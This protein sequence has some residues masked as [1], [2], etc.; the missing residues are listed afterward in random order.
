MTRA[1]DQIISLDDT[2]Y[3][4][5]MARCVRRAFLFGEDS[6]TGR[7]FDHRKAWVVDKL[8]FLSEVFAIDVCAY[9]VMSN[10]YHVVLRVNV[11]GIETW[12]VDEVIAR[13]TS[14][15]AGN[16]LVARYVA[17]ELTSP[18]E[19]NKV[20]EFAD[21]WRERLM[22]ISWFMRVL[23]ESIARMANEEDE[24]KGRF[25]EGRFKSQALLDEAA[26]L[27]C[28]AYVDLNP[29]RAGVAELPEES[30]FTSIQERVY[31]FANRGVGRP[32]LKRSS[33]NSRSAKEGDKDERSKTPVLYPFNKGVELRDEEQALPFSVEDYMQLLDW[34]GRALRDDKRGA[35]PESAPPIL[36]R[37]GLSIEAWLKFVP[38]V[39]KDFTHAIGQRE[40]M[41]S[42]ADKFDLA[43]LRGQRK[44]L[45][46][47]RQKPKLI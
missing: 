45:S 11:E 25:W 15:F 43:W 19:H 8:A 40:K 5:C 23:N 4:H 46:L 2:S 14:L 1:R 7:S 24:C 29:I 47:Y 28:M 35:I 30:D 12:S 27:A 44:A 6:V 9:A 39:E 38:A 10:H 26:V 36:S 42:F 3:Y 21:Q 22:D 16:A 41:Q 20:R 17:G 31:E 13:W 33:K 34:T 32:R 37:L 18:A